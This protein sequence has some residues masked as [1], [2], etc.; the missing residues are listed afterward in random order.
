MASRFTKL[1]VRLIGYFGAIYVEG[2]DDGCALV[3]GVE[4]SACGDEHHGAGI[5]HHRFGD[6]RA[7]P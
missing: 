6:D 2:R 3:L 7:L 1:C 5:R 4:E